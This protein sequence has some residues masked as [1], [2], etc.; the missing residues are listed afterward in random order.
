MTAVRIEGFAGI[1]PRVSDRLLPPQG[2]TVARNAKLLTGELRGLHELKVVKDF[3]GL[4]YAVRRAFRIPTDI[5]TPIP[6]QGLDHWVAFQD[7][8]VDFIRSPLAND[9]F[10]RFYWTSDS[11]LYSGVPKMNTKARIIAGNRR[12]LAPPRFARTCIRSCRHMARRVRRLSPHLVRVAPAHGI[13]RRW[14]PR[15]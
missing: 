11:T 8:D 13:S 6:I 4:G 14:T 12:R 3:T 15:L 5:N 2:A 7:A 9:S 1:A 10:D